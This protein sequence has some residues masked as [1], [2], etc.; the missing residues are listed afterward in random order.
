MDLN[1][2]FPH[3]RKLLQ[4]YPANYRKRY[5]DQ[6]LQTLADMLDDA[7]TRAQ[8]LTVWSRV[9]FD[10]PVSVAKQQL[11]YTG[12][13]MDH[14]M[15]S[16]IKRNA[17]ISA[18]LL[19]PFM[20]ALIANS[21]DQLANGSTLYYSWLWRM[22]VL[23]IWVLYLP[24]AA[25]VIAFVSLAIFLKRTKHRNWLR[26]VLD[27]RHDWPVVIVLL[28]G[29]SIL[30]L[31]QLHDTVQCVAGNPLREAHQLHQTWQC[32]Q[33]NQ[34]VTTTIRKLGL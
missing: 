25:A 17:I 13:V 24:L 7:P 18:A 27:I 14:E 10:T 28:A 34:G 31:V 8:K 15:P 29:V 2:R 9:A 11:I 20:L 21:A 19:V 33:Q 30:G 16:Y 6:M 4:L 22:P 26:A 32:V 23:G 12:E 1:R 3:Y 5:G